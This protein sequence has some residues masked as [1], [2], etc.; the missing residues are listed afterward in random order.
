MGHSLGPGDPFIHS[1]N[2]FLVGNGDEVAGDSGP[3]TRTSP[4]ALEGSCR[5]LL[6]GV[7]IIQSSI[8]Y[9]QSSSGTYTF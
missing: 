1:E 3:N 5:G 7:N 9:A 4:S 2:F 6:L 8:E